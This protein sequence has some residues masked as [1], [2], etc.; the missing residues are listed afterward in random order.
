MKEQNMGTSLEN[1]MPC[2]EIYYLINE[3][4]Y[5]MDHGAYVKA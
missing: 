1:F 2:H 4:C 5:I 3:F